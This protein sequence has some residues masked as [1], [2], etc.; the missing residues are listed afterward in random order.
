VE[1]YKELGPSIKL[2]EDEGNFIAPEER[3]RMSNPK[4]VLREWM[5]AEAYFKASP[6]SIQSRTFP[7]SIKSEEGDE[8]SY[9]S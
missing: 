7:V 6:S 9:D 1:T 4:Y 3:M 8:C 2:S 5:L